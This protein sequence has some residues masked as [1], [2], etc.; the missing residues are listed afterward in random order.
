METIILASGSPRRQE[1]LSKAKIPFRVIPPNIDE[2]YG[3][4]EE[5]VR[6]V[7]R[8]AE[9]KVNTIISLFKNESPRWILGVDTLVY[10]DGKIIGKPRTVDEARDT[11]SALSG[12]EHRVVSG[13][14]FLPSKNEKL[15][16]EIAVTEVRFKRMSDDEINYYINTG[17]WSG[18]AGGYRIQGIGSFFIEWIKG[19]YSNVMGL[20]METFY[21]IL[22]ESNYSLE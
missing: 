19:S 12:K 10:L 13:I 5:V 21:G 4:D 16:T 11:I 22:R 7:K 2:S 18:V 8:L 20:P 14:S 1:L 15:I 3:D 9:E 6:I 17:E